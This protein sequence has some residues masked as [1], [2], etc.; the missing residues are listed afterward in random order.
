MDFD[1]LLDIILFCDDD[2][3]G[4][5]LLNIH[6]GILFKNMDYY[7]ALEKV[8]NEN[9]KIEKFRPTR[10]KEQLLYFL[11]ARDEYTN[12]GKAERILLNIKLL[13]KCLNSYHLISEETIK[14]YNKKYN[15]S[16]E[17]WNYAVTKDLKLKLGNQI[18]K[19]ADY[20]K[21]GELPASDMK[22]ILKIVISAFI[23]H[24]FYYYFTM[25]HLIIINFD[26][27]NKAQAIVYKL[28][29][30]GYTQYIFDNK[31]GLRIDLKHNFYYIIY[32]YGKLNTTGINTFKRIHK[33]VLDL[34][35]NN[36]FNENCY[37]CSP[38]S[39]LKNKK[40]KCN[41]CK[42]ILDNFKYFQNLAKDKDLEKFFKKNF[43]NLDINK[44][45]AKI[46]LADC[47]NIAELRELRKQKL[48]EIL[49]MISFP[50][51]EQF[52]QYQKEKKLLQKLIKNTFT[53]KVIR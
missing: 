41:N 53:D 9:D 46:K 43:S 31:T 34:F 29:L 5:Y 32:E 13:E 12:K 7:G 48:I 8:N 2:L 49:D 42:N 4:Q 35:T 27:N 33:I 44:E 10:C 37:W 47:K 19:T 52:K 25:K 39:E 36:L 16:G 20:E 15:L 11:I 14:E 45:I 18:I 40:K 1:L 17:E 22:E 30:E 6:N 24:H 38:D 51:Y 50:N 28:F 26:E 3:V 21:A 23:T